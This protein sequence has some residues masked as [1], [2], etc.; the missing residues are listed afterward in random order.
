M[1]HYESNEKEII[2]YNV[3]IDLEKLMNIRNDVFEKFTE[4]MMLFP[5]QD[6]VGHLLPRLVFLI[7]S[8]I[9]LTILTPKSLQNHQPSMKENLENQING[10][11]PIMPNTDFDELISRIQ[12][13][14][15]YVSLNQSRLQSIDEM[16]VLSYYPKVLECVKMTEVSRVPVQ[17]FDKVADFFKGELQDVLEEL[18]QIKQALGEEE[19]GVTPKE[20]ESAVQKKIGSC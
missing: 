3:E 19:S 17:D 20:Q 8:L 7:D 12:K 2:K 4:E 14:Q 10:M 18:A 16:E 5:T 11:L 9:L 6:Y 13:Y 15:K 1:I